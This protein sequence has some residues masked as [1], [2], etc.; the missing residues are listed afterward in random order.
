MISKGER[1]R[2]GWQHSPDVTDARD[3]GPSVHLQWTGRRTIS[4]GPYG[5]DG[6]ETDRGIASIS[7]RM[8]G[9]RP[10]GV[11]LRA[12]ARS[13]LFLFPLTSTAAESSSLPSPALAGSRWCPSTR[14]RCRRDATGSASPTGVP[15]C[16]VTTG[17]ILHVACVDVRCI[18]RC[19]K[20]ENSE[21]VA[22]WL[23]RGC[24][25]PA[26]WHHCDD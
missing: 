24:C 12:P 10:S 21:C 8:K 4:H 11:R 15:A 16:P 14:L 9:R 25:R 26:R 7:H 5:D 23:H 2:K 13:L 1:E 20:E 22:L 19:V 18:A 3:A 6:S 17:S